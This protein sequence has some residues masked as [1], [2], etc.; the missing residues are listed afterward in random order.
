MDQH[1][2]EQTVRPLAIDLLGV[3]ETQNKIQKKNKLKKEKSEN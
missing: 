2:W 1:N 3:D